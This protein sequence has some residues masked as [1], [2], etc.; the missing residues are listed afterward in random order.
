[1][2]SRLLWQ[3]VD[4]F[5]KIRQNSL[6]GF[7]DISWD[8]KVA[9]LL[10]DPQEMWSFNDTSTSKY[11]VS[12]QLRLYLSKKYIVSFQLLSLNYHSPIDH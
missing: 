7:E 8:D 10:H 11:I 3:V 5:Y 2:H 9:C 4:K 1:M 12:F 6:T